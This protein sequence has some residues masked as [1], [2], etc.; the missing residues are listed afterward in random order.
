MKTSET[1]WLEGGVLSVIEVSVVPIILSSCSAEPVWVAVD[2][3]GD[4]G[5]KQCK[6][7]TQDCPWLTPASSIPANGI[8]R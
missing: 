8:V 6:P 2:A 7:Q 1:S 3:L 5:F 4:T